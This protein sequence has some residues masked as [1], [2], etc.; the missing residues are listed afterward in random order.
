MNEYSRTAY[1][2]FILLGDVGGFNGAIIIFPAFVFSFYSASMY[3]KS[4][5]QGTL[6]RE[7]DSNKRVRAYEAQQ[8][9]KRIKKNAMSSHGLTEEDLNEIEKQFKTV[10]KYK[11]SFC[12]SLMPNNCLSCGKNRKREARLREKISGR[13]EK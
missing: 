9:K 3:E 2:F 6:V 13:L 7:I 5:S 1:T 12:Q 11:G 8:N 4:L 10:N